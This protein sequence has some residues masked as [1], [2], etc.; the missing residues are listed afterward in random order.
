MSKNSENQN[1][2]LEQTNYLGCNWLSRIP[3]KNAWQ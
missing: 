3:T 1:N 2:T